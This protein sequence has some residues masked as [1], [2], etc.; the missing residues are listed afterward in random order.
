MR[1]EGSPE[2]FRAPKKRS[3]MEYFAQSGE[4]AA[5]SWLDDGLGYVVSAAL[6]RERLGRLAEAVH[7]RVMD[8]SA[9]QSKRL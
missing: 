3:A 8:G 5:F 4:I 2:A 9:A 7:P 6:D 1:R